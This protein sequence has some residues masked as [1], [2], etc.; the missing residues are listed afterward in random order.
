MTLSEMAE[1][2]C[3]L[4]DMVFLLV[5]EGSTLLRATLPHERNT[6]NCSDATYQRHTA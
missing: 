6:N 4:I 5:V 2:H 3:C 1:L